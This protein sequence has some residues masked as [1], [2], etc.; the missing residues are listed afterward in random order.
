[1]D[2]KFDVVI[3]TLSEAGEVHQTVGR[4]GDSDFYGTCTKPECPWTGE[5]SGCIDDTYDEVRGHLGAGEDL[6]AFTFTGAGRVMEIADEFDGETGAQDASNLREVMATAFD[7]PGL[8][9]L[10]ERNTRGHGCYYSLHGSLDEAGA[11][12]DSQEYPEDFAVEALVNLASGTRYTPSVS[13][14]WDEVK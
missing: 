11:Y 5:T 13:I 3:A 7:L 12:L 6:P 8:H 4:F 14:V 1:M 10:V 2:T 9:L